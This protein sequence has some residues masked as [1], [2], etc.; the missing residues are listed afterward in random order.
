[1]ENLLGFRP[2]PKTLNLEKKVETLYTETFESETIRRVNGSKRKFQLT[3]NLFSPA[4][5]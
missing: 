3:R 1:M 4:K 5:I 2:Y